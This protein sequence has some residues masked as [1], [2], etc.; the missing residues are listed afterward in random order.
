MRRGPTDGYDKAI[1][2]D[3]RR[4]TYAT[5]RETLKKLH[6]SVAS[7]SALLMP[8]LEGD[9]IEVALNA[10]FREYNLHVVDDNPAIV[11]TLK[12]RYPKI[13][14]YG[15]LVSRAM[16]RMA[17]EGIRLDCANFDLTGNVS[18]KF[19][20]EL[21]AIS[22]IGSLP[23]ETT[24]QD[25]VIQTTVNPKR[26]ST[27]VFGDVAIVALCF[28]RA[29]EP[30]ALTNAWKADGGFVRD[31][32]AFQQ[33]VERV[34]SQFGNGIV[35]PCVE[36]LQKTWLLLSELDR[37]RLFGILGTL[38]LTTFK[39]PD[40]WKPNVELVR[41]EQYCSARSPMMW[42]IAEVESAKRKIER[43]NAVNAKL[44]MLGLP[45]R[46]NSDGLLNPLGT[47]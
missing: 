47:A 3:Y 23:C 29:R 46:Y 43:M 14:T 30:K 24:V 38:G 32:E 35:P 25:G 18:A 11:A 8:S 5:F 9:E 17:H 4:K 45:P 34:V 33:M 2:R 27:G 44:A 36:R 31:D 6:I 13:N 39:V 1:K 20:S 26:Y 10:G 12:K 15:V 42:V 7:A 41:S 28:L 37:Y 19:V 16:Q 21:Y 22:T 40:K